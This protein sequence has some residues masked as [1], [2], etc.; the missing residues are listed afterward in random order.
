MQGSYAA[1]LKINNSTEAVKNV[2]LAGGA[3]A[4]VSFNVTRDEAG[5]YNVDIG[6][7]TD[8][9]TVSSS[10]AALGWSAIAGIITSVVI[11]GVAATYLFMRRRGLAN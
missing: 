9:F 8:E 7:Q 3:K 5:T 2:T 10:A 6:G 1:T 4:T 11:L